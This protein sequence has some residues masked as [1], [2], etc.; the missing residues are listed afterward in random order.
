MRGVQGGIDPGGWENPI[1][2]AV[3]ELR[4]ETGITSAR[5]VQVVSSCP[6]GFLLG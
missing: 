5:L 2:A 3:R 6:D 1:S 4:E